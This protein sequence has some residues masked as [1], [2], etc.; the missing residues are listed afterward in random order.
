MVLIE[1]APVSDA[2]PKELEHYA[3]VWKKLEEQFQKKS[4]VNRL[5]LRRK[6]HSL[7]LKDGESVLDHVKTMLETFNE[8]L[9]VCDAITD[10]E[11]V[12]YLL[13]SFVQYVG[14]CVGIKLYCSRDGD[15]DQ[16]TDA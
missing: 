7:R 6:L 11:R 2:D 14:D 4:W 10:E 15:C 5:N 13:A 16:E 3:A 9:I 12:V 8:L 1:E